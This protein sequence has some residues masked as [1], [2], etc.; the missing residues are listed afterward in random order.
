M[1]KTCVHVEGKLCTCHCDYCTFR[2]RRIARERAIN[3][4]KLMGE[5]N[6]SI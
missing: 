4:I 5:R 1:R 6:D 3:C 2:N